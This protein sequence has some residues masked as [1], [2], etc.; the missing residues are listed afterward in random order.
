MLSIFGTPFSIISPLIMRSLID[1][2]LIWTNTFILTPLHLVTSGI[3]FISAFLNYPS[4]LGRGTLYID[5]YRNFLSSIFAHIQRVE[6]ASLQKFR[7]GD[8]L[9]RV[10]GKL[11]PVVQTAI[12]TIPNILVISLGI[13][14]P[15]GIMISMDVTLAVAVIV[16]EVLFVFSAAWF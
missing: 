15:L 3:F 9:S 10:T 14:M 7:T 11:T 5:L 13:T 12:R 8:L 1:D 2:V 4:A 16:P 6:Y